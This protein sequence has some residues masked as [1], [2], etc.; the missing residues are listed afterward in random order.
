MAVAN[1]RWTHIDVT[2]CDRLEVRYLSHFKG[3]KQAT[4]K[5]PYG[6]EDRRRSLARELICGGQAEDACKTQIR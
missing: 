5:L 2:G 4:I 1:P 3:W 6:P